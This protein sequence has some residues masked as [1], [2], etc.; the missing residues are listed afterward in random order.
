[1]KPSSE[2]AYLKAFA[3]ESDRLENNLAHTISSYLESGKLKDEEGNPLKDCICPS[4][5]MHSVIDLEKDDFLWEE[6]K[7]KYR[8]NFNFGKYLFE[9]AWFVTYMVRHYGSVKKALK[10]NYPEVRAGA[11]REILGMDKWKV[12]TTVMVNVCWSA[13]AKIAWNWNKSWTCD[14]ETLEDKK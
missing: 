7:K 5:I 14:H 12:L 3:H 2:Y 13:S 6:T 10:A 11:Y 9:K 8:K 4:C 1:M